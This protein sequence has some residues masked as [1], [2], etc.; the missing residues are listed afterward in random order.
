MNFVVRDAEI[1][2]HLSQVIA[3]VTW[4]AHL[5]MWFIP[6]TGLGPW[7]VGLGVGLVY[8]LLIALGAGNMKAKRD[9][10]R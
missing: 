2:L 3:V 8:T 10:E 7:S 5:G 4:L 1:N 9:N 6:L